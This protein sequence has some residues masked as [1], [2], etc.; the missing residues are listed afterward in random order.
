MALCSSKGKLKSAKLFKTR[1]EDYTKP[2]L[3]FTVYGPNELPTPEPTPYDNF[4]MGNQD[5]EDDT[6][7][8]PIDNRGIDVAEAH[9]GSEPETGQEAEVS[10]WTIYIIVGSVAGGVLLI[11]LA[12]IVVA[13]CCNRIEES[14]YKS[15]SV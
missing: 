14:G 5:T 4:E 15:T 12:A 1:Q 7:F 6:G 10:V 11:G 8:K 9:G 3:S 2:N 13:V